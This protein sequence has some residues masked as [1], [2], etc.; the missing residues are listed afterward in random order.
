MSDVE[1]LTP[2]QIGDVDEALRAGIPRDLALSAAGISAKAYAYYRMQAAEGNE[3]YAEWLESMQQAEASAEVEHLKKLA[4]S[5]EWRAR[6][7]LLERLHPGKYGS[8]QEA[9]QADEAVKEV[10]L[11]VSAKA[12]EH[13]L[14]WFFEEVLDAVAEAD[15]GR[16]GPAD[17]GE[18]TQQDG[19]LH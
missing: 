6:L 2:D 16:D 8:K 12:K 18:K 11:I 3:G 1:E 14:Q 15:S 9:R 4:E 17:Q 7:I 19:Q 5:K 13:D 10:L